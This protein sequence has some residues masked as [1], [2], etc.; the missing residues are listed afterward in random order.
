MILNK[1]KF[2]SFLIVLLTLAGCENKNNPDNKAN[3]PISVGVFDVAITDAEYY[4]RYPVILKALN[5]VE[6]RPQVNGYITGIYFKEGDQ[7]TKGQKLYAIDQQQQEAN[8]QQAL[9][10]LSVQQANLEKAQK[11]VERYRVLDRKDAI[12]KQQVDY[13]EANYTAAL[14]QL[15]AAKAT[16][17]GVQT[18]LRYTTITAPF[19]GTIGISQVRLGA[20]VSIGNTL[21][22][23]ISTADPIAADIVIDQKEIFWFTEMLKRPTG[24]VDSSFKLIIS[25]KEYA[26][27]GKL[28]LIDRA[29]DPQTGTIRI[30]VEFPNQN[31]LLRPG[32]NGTLQIL[33]PAAHAVVIPYK[34]I[35]QQLGEFYVYSIKNSIATQS[36]VVPEVQ[37]GENIVIKQGL[38]PGDVIIAEGLQSIKEGSPV[39]V[40]RDNSAETQ[41]QLNTKK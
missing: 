22:N 4:E 26:Q 40:S 37:I 12:A 7:V 14:Q 33:K 15:E 13:A 1:L 36:K 25:N 28:S 18:S 24:K 27:L 10:S 34:C 17:R 30:R 3:A 11:D 9:A 39:T 29:V 5:E 2:S 35:I 23:T 8:Y 20:S 31:H 6:L 16:V 19:S 32:M 41:T 21:L 38:K